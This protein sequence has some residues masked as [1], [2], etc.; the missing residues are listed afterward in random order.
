MRTVLTVDNS[1]VV[2]SMVARGIESLGC[3]LI[4][5]DDA[6]EGLAAARMHRPD[7]V[8]LDVAAQAADAERLLAALRADATT[9]G[10]PV[11][12]LTADG[13]ADVARGLAR[14]GVSGSVAKP[15]R[16]EALE[17][18]VRRVLR[19]GGAA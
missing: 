17:V 9:R 19:E 7:L 18:E 5:A 2:R 15:F 8:L 1:K 12:L 14:L 13:D 6:D 3:R 10:I 11:I 4:E 16:T